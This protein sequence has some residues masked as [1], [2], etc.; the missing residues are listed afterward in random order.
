MS[1]FNYR[2]DF[3]IWQQLLFRDPETGQYSDYGFPEYNFKCQY[4]TTNRA[5]CYEAEC[6]YVDGTAVCKNCR[7]ENGK[8]IIVFDNHRLQPGDLH[9][10]IVI[11]FPNNLYP[12]GYQN[13]PISLKTNVRLVHGRSE[14]PTL[15]E[16]MAI[17]P[18]IKG[19]D[20]KNFDYS[21]LTEEQKEELAKRVADNIEVDLPEL[22]EGIED[23]T[24]EE[25]DDIMG[26][27][28]TDLHTINFN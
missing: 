6:K 10:E 27:P 20:G 24:E 3:A 15:A 12:D 4:W 28:E 23:I 11:D 7:N 19:K 2:Q 25:W 14:V 13:S 26:E 16:A 21:D 18:Y 22:T 8:L 17:M 9:G 5:N 1:H